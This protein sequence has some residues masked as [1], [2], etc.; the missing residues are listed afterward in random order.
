MAT[1]ARSGTRTDVASGGGRGPRLPGQPPGHLHRAG[2]ALEPPG[3]HGV[4]GGVARQR[5]AG[6]G[7]RSLGEDALAADGGGAGGLG[8]DDGV[9]RVAG[10]P[11]DGRDSGRADLDL[12]RGRP[13]GLPS[14]TLRGAPKACPA[15]ATEIFT[16]LEPPVGVPAQ[17]TA[18]T[19]PGPIGHVRLRGDLA[20]RAHGGGRRPGDDARRTPRHLHQTTGDPR[21]DRGPGAVGRQH[22]LGAGGRQRAGRGQPGLGAAPGEG[23]ASTAP[24]TPARHR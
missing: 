16:A 7:A 17:T 10:G 5:D 21:G 12:G 8:A 23:T 2:R 9:G 6:E 11:H 24:T 14:D 22:H 19:P 3:G 4:A 1:A 18:V 15:G 20:G 13:A